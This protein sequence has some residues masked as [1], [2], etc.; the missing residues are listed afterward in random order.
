MA[1]M[2]SRRRVAL[3]S[4]AVLSAALL[5]AASPA[6]ATASGTVVAWGCGG[7]NDF[8]QCSVP[9][10]L[11][12]V[13]A[14]AAGSAHSLA[15]KS[16]G[17]VVAGGCIAG[18]VF[19]A[20]D[21]GQCSVPNGLGGVAAIAAGYAHNL[22]LKSNG[23]VVAWG[24]GGILDLGQCR[25]PRGLSRVT[26]I[27]AGGAHSLALVGPPPSIA[28]LSTTASGNIAVVRVKI[29]DWKLYPALV[30]RKP[31]EPDG[32]HWRIFVDGKYNSFS[33]SST[34]GRTTKL[35]VGKHRIRVEL[36]NNDRSHVAG[37]LPSR[38]LTV[39]IKG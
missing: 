19:V 5:V 30:G 33:T 18:P 31:N 7:G 38:T 11:A 28:L 15:L 12:G 36:A 37:T 39:V 34:T 29:S 1:S 6:Q 23:T 13:T 2:R 24:C 3:L 35:R 22:A 26:A 14:I 4:L 9:V 32:G 16:D 27:A 8:G 21:F 17:T 25:V 20:T 10:G